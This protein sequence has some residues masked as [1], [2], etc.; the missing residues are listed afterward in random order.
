MNVL[1]HPKQAMKKRESCNKCLVRKTQFLV[2][3]RLKSQSNVG[4]KGT[5]F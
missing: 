3:W 2:N 5:Y 1:E 4:A